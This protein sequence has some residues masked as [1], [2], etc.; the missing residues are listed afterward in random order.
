MYFDTFDLT[1]DP[2]YPRNKEP[3][4]KAP[5]AFGCSITYGVGVQPNETWA[6]LLGLVNCSA[7]GSSN[8]KILR[9]SIS[10]CNTFNPDV[11]YVCWTFDQRREWVDETGEILRW[12]PYNSN[13]PNEEYRWRM[14]HLELQNSH[15]DKYNAL[16]NK[17]ML[18]MFCSS[19]KI[20]L[21]DFNI[22]NPIPH[23]SMPL[24]SDN[25]HPGPEWHAAI[26]EYLSQTH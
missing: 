15:W 11:I 18:N 10:Y 24:G 5:A 22:V 21:V 20:K 7:P 2:E 23:D 4:L 12:Q 17:F 6:S 19:R 3:T 13:K 8:D 16:K 1:E 14:A 9:R 26:A 25:L